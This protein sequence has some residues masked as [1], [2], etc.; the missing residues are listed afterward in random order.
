MKRMTTLAIFASLWSFA[1]GP[2]LAAQQQPGSTSGPA[3][4]TYVEPPTA[5]QKRNPSNAA[6]ADRA[7]SGS[8]AV[9]SPGVEG[10]P[11]TQSGAAPEI[12]SK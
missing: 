3:V 7:A 1:A 6:S 4:G 8:T 5:V 12:N 10:S 11:G 9:G 2:A